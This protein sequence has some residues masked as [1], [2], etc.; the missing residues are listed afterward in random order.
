MLTLTAAEGVA[1]KTRGTLTVIRSRQ[2]LTV[3]ISSTG[4]TVLYALI[5]VPATSSGLVT[6]VSSAAHTHIFTKGTVS[7]TLLSSWTWL[8]FTTA[9]RLHFHTT[10]PGWVAFK[11]RWALTG[12]TS[13]LI[14]ADSSNTTWVIDTFVYISASK[15]TDGVTIVPLS[16]DTLWL[17]V[18][19]LTVGIGTTAYIL[20]RICSLKPFYR[21]GVL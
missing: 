13:R 11:T 18:D 8:S 6:S 17:S 4:R 5:Y 12:K 10:F 9:W 1:N 7:H 19:E 3:G 14:T 16:T 21:T 20:T 2:I 15:H